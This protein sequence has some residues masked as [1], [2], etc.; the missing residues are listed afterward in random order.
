M[1]SELRKK[2]CKALSG[3]STFHIDSRIFHR[4]RGENRPR[5]GAR[6]HHSGH[7]STDHAA[8]G[9]GMR[10]LEGNRGEFLPGE[11]CPKYT[12]V[13]AAVVPGA[14]ELE[15]DHCRLDRRHGDGIGQLKLSALPVGVRSSAAN[16]TGSRMQRPTAA[17][18]ERASPQ[19]SGCHRDVFIFRRPSSDIFVA[20]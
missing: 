17:I 3:P 2:Q 15:G 12:F 19:R 7:H 16:I 14:A 18:E 5:S 20:F 9:I 10:C 1:C 8:R 13:V 11:G 4:R 6:H